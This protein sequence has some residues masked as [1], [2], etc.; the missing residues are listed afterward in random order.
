M[1]GRRPKHTRAEARQAVVGIL[2]RPGGIDAMADEICAVFDRLDRGADAEPPARCQNP[3]GPHPGTAL[4]NRRCPICGWR[5]PGTQD[6][7]QE[8]P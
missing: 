2:S 7:L 1:T 8:N 6:T 5:P 3:D 4:E